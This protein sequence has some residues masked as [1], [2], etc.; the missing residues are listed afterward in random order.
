M[1]VEL[2]TLLFENQLRKKSK[3]RN[4]VEVRRKRFRDKIQCHYRTSKGL[5]AMQ[6]NNDSVLFPW[7]LHVEPMGGS[8]KEA[9]AISTNGGTF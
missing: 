7:I 6:Q 4:C 3:G 1:M 9:N 5:S 2:K 8:A